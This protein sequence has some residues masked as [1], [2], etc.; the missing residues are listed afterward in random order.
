[1]CDCLHEAI[2][3]EIW[4]YSASYGAKLCLAG[5]K[6]SSLWLVAGYCV[7]NL[8]GDDFR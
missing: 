8:A 7:E 1:M 4:Q 6:I 3:Q 5:H 2:N